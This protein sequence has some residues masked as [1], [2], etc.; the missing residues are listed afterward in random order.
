MDLRMLAHMRT[1]KHTTRSLH[2]RFSQNTEGN[3]YVFIEFTSIAFSTKHNLC[4]IDTF[5]CKLVIVHGYLSN[6]TI[7]SE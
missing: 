3:K 6:Q 5:V 1:H 7:C 4:G 2:A